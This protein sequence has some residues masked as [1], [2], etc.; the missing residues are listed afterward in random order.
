M[1]MG[2]GNLW[3]LKEQI[4]QFAVDSWKG[5]QLTNAKRSTDDE[6]VA[7]PFYEVVVGNREELK[8]HPGF[9]NIC[10]HKGLSTNA[11]RDPTLGAP[12]D[13][14]NAARDWP[15]LNFI[16]YHSCIRPGFWT[17]NALQ[18]IRAGESGAVPLREGVPDIL[19]T[20]EF[21]VT[22]APFSNVYAEIGTTFASTVVTFPT[23]WAHIIG[24]LLKFM[25]PDRIVFGSDSLWYGGPQWQI[26]AFWRFQIPE[27]LQRRWG[28]PAL[29]E[30]I[31]RKILGLN[32]A[33]LYKLP[34]ASDAAHGAY[35]PVPNITSEAQVPPEL[36]TLLE[37]PAQASDNFS[38]MRKQY[39]EAGGERSNTRHGWIRTRV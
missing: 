32:S 30:S 14:P 23:V 7:Y 28:Y 21:A 24:Q 39:V 27:E 5:Y 2:A 16:I 29:T 15:E 18:D 35:R 19:W 37:F 6:A 13:I 34:A 12:T 20:T 25:G 10:V 3:Y 26:E 31:K 22:S 4:D 1:Y 36:L 17:F 38:K 8:E 11:P 9:F 33:R